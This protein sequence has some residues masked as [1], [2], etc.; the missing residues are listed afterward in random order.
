M[1]RTGTGGQS[2]PEELEALRRC[3]DGIDARLVELLA[4]RREVVGRVAE[5]KRRRN[6]PLYHPAREEDLISRRR[7]QAEEVGLDADAVEDVF[8][9]LLRSSR[10]AQSRFLADHGVRAGAA[11]VLVG[12]RGSMGRGLHRWFETAGYAVRILDREDWARA[13]VLCA[14]ADLALLAVPIDATAPVARRLAP[15]LP[16]TCVLADITSVKA[17]PLRAM[18][19]AHPGPV[20]GLHPMFGPTTTTMDKQIVVATPGRDEAAC[21]WVLDQLS[22]WGAVVVRANAEEHD[23]AMAVVQ[24]LRHFATFAF[25]QFLFRR[26][27]DLGRTLD[28]SG[29]IYRLEL[30]M[31]GRLFAQDPDLYAEIVFATPARR[32][33]LREY[34]E[35]VAENLAM[36]ETRDKEGF[37]REFRRIAQWFG[38]F[39]DQAM[40]ESSYLIEKLVERF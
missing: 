31:V 4:E 7:Q 5:E 38:P 9:L 10:V 3:I 19:D 15:H 11:V 29:P 32:A 25:G 21:Q 18:L 12:G 36:I 17:E 6:L 16:R 34:L 23:E 39:G 33:L 1:P 26:G 27:V 20:L 37:C 28:F 8:R 2:S 22:A 13:D 35:S 14:G 40:R 30:G 24:A